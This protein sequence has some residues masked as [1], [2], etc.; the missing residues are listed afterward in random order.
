MNQIISPIAIDL[1][2]KNSGVVTGNI[3]NEDIKLN[4]CLINVDAGISFSLKDRTS[5]RHQRR[6][7]K[8]IKLAKRLF[9]HIFEESFNISASNLSNKEINGLF[10]RRGYTYLSFEISNEDKDTINNGDPDYFNKILPELFTDNKTKLYEQLTRIKTLPKDIDF[11]K[12]KE[13]H[14]KDKENKETISKIEILYQNLK[15]ESLGSFKREDYFKN[16]K[17]EINNFK[18]E[19]D[20]L[21]LFNLIG[22]INNLQ[23]RVLRKYFNNIN[24][25]KLNKE[26]L[27]KVILNWIYSWHF[28]KKDEMY[29]KDNQKEIK[30]YFKDKNKD[31]LSFLTE[32]EPNKT[33]PPYEDQNNRLPNKCASLY[34]SSEKLTKKY[35]NWQIILEKLHN[36]KDLEEYLDL[37]KDTDKA[38]LLQRY[39]D[40]TKEIDPFT[41]REVVDCLSNYQTVDSKKNSVYFELENRIGENFRDILYKIAQNYYN[42]VEN[43]KKGLWSKDNPDSLLT[44]CNINPPHKKNVDYLN[45]GNILFYDMTKEKLVDFRRDCWEQKI[46]DLNKTLKSW[47]LNTEHERKKHGNRFKYIYENQYKNTKLDDNNKK[48]NKI[49]DESEIIGKF[50]NKH[51]KQNEIFYKKYNNP[52]SLAQLANILETDIHGYSKSCEHCLIEEKW[53]GQFDGERANASKL[54]KDSV[55][56][57]DGMLRKILDSQAKIIA[58]IKVKEIKQLDN[59]NILVP[60]LIEE[61]E[62]EFTESL[63]EI[64]K[65]DNKSKENA[66]NNKEKNEKRIEENYLKKSDRIKDFSNNICPYS[67]ETISI[68]ENGEIDHII[69]R[70]FSKKNYGTIFNH[71]ANLIYASVKGNQQKG[72][73]VYYLKDLNK[74]YLKSQY[75]TYDIQNIENTIE[76]SLKPLLNLNKNE[77]N[78]IIF[79]NLEKYEQKN[80]RHSLFCEKKE[81]RDIGIEI[82]RANIRK[83]KVNGTQSFFAKLII[84]KIKKYFLNENININF[85]IIKVDNIKLS[86]FRRNLAEYNNKF[87]KKDIQSSYSHIIDASLCL[88]YEMLFDNLIENL[89]IETDYR[90]WVMDNLPKNFSIIG[91][92]KRAICERDDKNSFAATPIFQDSIYAEN[93]L[94]MIF[95][96]NTLRIGF[97]P[98][99]SFIIEE[100]QNLFFDLINDYLVIKEPYINKNYQE[101][102]NLSKNNQ[103][104]FSFDKKKCLEL[105]QKSFKDKINGNSIDEKTQN[106]IKIIDGVRYTTK[107]ENIDSI[108]L[109]KDKK[110]TKSLEIKDFTIKIEISQINGVI[111]K[112]ILQTLNLPVIQEWKNIEQEI[113]K[114][115]Q[116]SPDIDYSTLSEQVYNNFYKNNNKNERFH[117]KYARKMSLPIIANPSGGFRIKRKNPNGETIYQL[118]AVKAYGYGFDKNLDNIVIHPVLANSKNISL[119]NINEKI[120]I[121]KEIIKMNEW[122]DVEMP[123][124][125]KND[126]IKLE[127]SPATKSRF[128]VRFFIKKDSFLQKLII[129]EYKE[130]ISND[131]FNLRDKLGEKDYNKSFFEKSLVKPRNTIEILKIDE[132]SIYLEYEADGKMKELFLKGKSLC[133]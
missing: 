93:F 28:V 108:L 76:N 132:D 29:K 4:G 18:L 82:I 60:I 122:R 27:K 51:L 105:L 89:E 70:T 47:C 117:K 48:I 63:L 35:L 9:W 109:D 131:I 16:I 59:K 85:D 54:T 57:I 36:D 10:N 34:L 118:I 104:I 73:K 125:L 12:I 79:H 15:K 32:I 97:N 101:I 83:A 58:E 96:K 116:K 6:G 94:S 39:F 21:K 92:H 25:E 71:E 121:D 56:P 114:L 20:K 128:Y 69:S 2:A 7:I 61:N 8:R 103:L 31:I 123:E 115:K 78:K 88:F 24:D 87:E 41:F 84:S 30:N 129:E 126:I 100:N 43:A 91:T 14:K 45:I 65:K 74:D 99:N 26:K 17:K 3:F 11:K 38:R 124:D 77:I 72:N 95:Y 46:P 107:R 86:D 64:K 22:N 119:A 133:T 98:K 49:F 130:L 102:L 33:I 127:L 50:I 68:G 113:I 62:F 75:E 106:Q 44:K 19:I 67:K 37:N 120:S 40:R 5:K 13:N 110:N 81:I 53:R 66:R 80:I 55:R 52:F 42:D 1:G 23:L 112:K 111:K 90:K